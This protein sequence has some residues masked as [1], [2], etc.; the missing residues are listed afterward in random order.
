QRPAVNPLLRELLAL[1]VEL[2]V[3]RG[4]TPTPAEYLQ[5]FP[6]HDDLVAEAF[7][8]TAGTEP[9]D[10]TPTSA[11]ALRYRALGPYRLL[12][13]IGRGGMG[14][15]YEA[16]HQPLGRRVA[17]KVLLLHPLLREHQLQRFLR[18]A[19]IVARLEHP[20]IVPIHDVGEHEGVHFFAMQL[21]AGH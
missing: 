9:N 7:A 21:I 11:P 18:E 19:R 12:P 2:R 4:E 17:L 13:E 5:R 3:R 6:G 14:V 15:V 16:E 10:T 20:H 8:S 1:E